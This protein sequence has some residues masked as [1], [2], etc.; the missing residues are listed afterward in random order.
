MKE[1]SSYVVMLKVVI[2]ISKMCKTTKMLTRSSKVC[3]LIQPQRVCTLLF[4]SRKWE[5]HIAY[6]YILRASKLEA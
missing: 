6:M 5:T 3:D 4:S 2:A 1:K